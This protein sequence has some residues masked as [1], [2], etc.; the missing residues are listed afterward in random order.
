MSQPTL[1]RWFTI[2]I[3]M[4]FCIS[5]ICFAFLLSFDVATA[6]AAVTESSDLKSLF[7]ELKDKGDFS[8]EDIEAIQKG[9]LIIKKLPPTHK[10]EIGVT[11][12]IKL[13]APVRIVEQALLQVIKNQRRKN[14]RQ[15]GYLSDPPSISDFRDMEFGKN[16]VKD[17]ESCTVGK[18]K[19]NLSA[20]MIRELQDEVDWSAPNAVAKARVTLKRMIHNYLAEYWE[21]GDASLLTYNDRK[22]AVALRDEYIDMQKSF[23]WIEEGAPE[24]ASY[25]RQYPGVELKGIQRDV[26]WSEVKIAL[27][28]VFIF[29]HNINYRS[30][31]NGVPRFMSVSK[32][33]FA[34]HYFD[35][36][37]NQTI[38]IPEDK[39]SEYTYVLFIN[40][41]RAGALGGRLGG[42]ARSLISGRAESRLETVLNDTKR[43]SRNAMANVES[44][45]ESVED[46]GF[47][48]HIR[49][50]P[51]YLWI[52]GFVPFVVVVSWIVV[53]LVRRRGIS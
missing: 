46:T 34:N 7:E 20:A 14:A 2:V 40:R 51:F 39:G 42:L 11:G 27:K 15:H 36:S 21:K 52:A 53:A 49:A 23:F 3:N 28:H 41:S 22:S 33:L 13:N 45:E 30:R 6:P 8:A 12:V 5:I 38:L 17:L 43:F 24:F 18:C 9:Q 4:K 1:A 26:T 19:W 10:R 48:A 29:T 35:S 25:V 37:L 16:D 32:Q 47:L 31:V 44:A 50:N